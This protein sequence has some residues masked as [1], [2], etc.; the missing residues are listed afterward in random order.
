MKK[1]ILLPIV[2]LLSMS[3]AYGMEENKGV[4]A[5]FLSKVKHWVVAPIIGYSQFNPDLHEDAT[6]EY[7]RL[8]KQAYEA[9]QV[10]IHERLPIKKMEKLSNEI[11]D[12]CAGITTASAI[13]IN[14]ECLRDESFATK[15]AII[16]HE[17]THAKYHDA[18]MTGLTGLGSTAGKFVP[19]VVIGIGL[20]IATDQFFK[21]HP[22]KI[23]L[24]WLAI[25]LTVP[26]IASAIDCNCKQY[27]FNQQQLHESRADETALN[28]LNCYKCLLELE[29]ECHFDAYEIQ[30][31]IDKLGSNKHNTFCAEHQN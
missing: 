24:S 25:P 3:S 9:L 11:K 18:V 27:A 5:L 13:F 29:T 8:G 28:A 14:G 2:L 6:E 23:I 22:C 30:K 20:A 16:L 17:V 15:K 1:N 12:N 26:R 7:Q 4:K 19:S 31:V 21:E 10:P